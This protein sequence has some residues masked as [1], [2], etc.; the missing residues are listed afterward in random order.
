MVIT[1]LSNKTYQGAE[2]PEM[3]VVILTQKFP[4]FWVRRV[5]WA[6][7][8]TLGLQLTGLLSF[9]SVGER[10]LTHLSVMSRD[11]QKTSKGMVGTFKIVYL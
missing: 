1:R 11:K 2:L 8:L 7:L 3:S 4:E 9:S 6:Q 10:N 5:E